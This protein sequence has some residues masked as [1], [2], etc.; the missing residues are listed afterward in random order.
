MASRKHYENQKQ[1]VR[2]YLKGLGKKDFVCTY[3]KVILK[4]QDDFPNVHFSVRYVVR[5]KTEL[6]VYSIII[7][8]TEKKDDGG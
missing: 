7:D 1:V 5:A 2:E 6:Y 4:L 3:P 8:N